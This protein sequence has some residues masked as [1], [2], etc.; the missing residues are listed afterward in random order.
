MLLQFHVLTLQGVRHLCV[1]D[2]SR[3][4]FYLGFS[5]LIRPLD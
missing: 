3:W 5:R 2:T 4:D 1:V